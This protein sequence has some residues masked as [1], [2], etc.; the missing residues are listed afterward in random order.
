MEPYGS[1]E[2]PWPCG[3]CGCVVPGVSVGFNAP[4]WPQVEAHTCSHLPI[5]ATFRLSINHLSGCKDPR[6]NRQRSPSI[7]GNKPSFPTKWPQHRCPVIM[8]LHS[9][10]EVSSQ[11][12]A[13][14]RC[15]AYWPFG[16]RTEKTGSFYPG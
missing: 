11:A 13:G 3:Y 5:G 16:F 9:S 6:A 8:H 4:H 2:L 14:P 15:P 12:K 10:S 7:S 1:P